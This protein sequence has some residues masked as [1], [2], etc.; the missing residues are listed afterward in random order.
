MC[1]V[2]IRYIYS[3]NCHL[4]FV[5]AWRSAWLGRFSI[6]SLS[7][8][9]FVSLECFI[10]NEILNDCTCEKSARYNGYRDKCWNFYERYKTLW[11]YL[12]LATGAAISKFDAMDVSCVR[13]RACMHVCERMTADLSAFIPVSARS[14]PQLSSFLFPTALFYAYR[15]D[16]SYCFSLD[17][18]EAS[19]SR[20]RPLSRIIYSQLLNSRASCVSEIQTFTPQ[21]HRIVN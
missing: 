12:G 4:F 14:W 19:C 15:R 11:I 17:S 2:I 13:A 7:Y 6:L 5:A 16:A 21:I 1:E 3:D 10:S 9:C 8:S 18:W 20:S